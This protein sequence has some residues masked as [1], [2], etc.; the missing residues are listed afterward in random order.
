MGFEPFILNHI[1]SFRRSDSTPNFE[2]QVRAVLHFMDQQD[3][4]A[5]T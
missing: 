4:I 3:K 2:F 5:I 1:N